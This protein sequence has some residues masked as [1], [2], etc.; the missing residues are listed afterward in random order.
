MGISGIDSLT[1]GVADVAASRRFFED[2]GLSLLDGATD[3]A[4]VLQLADGGTICLRAAN[5][6]ALPALPPGYGQAPPSTMREVIWGVH[7][8]DDLQAIEAELGRDRPV[9]RDAD[10]TLHTRDDL[11]YAI[12]FRVTRRHALTHEAVRD[13]GP[14][15]IGRIDARAEAALP[16]RVQQQRMVHL[17]Y[18]VPRQSQQMLQ[19][20]VERLGFHVTESVKNVGHFLRCGA[21]GDHHN[22]FLQTRGDNYGF[23]H[24]AFELRNIDDVMFC[25]QHMEQQGWKSHLGPGRHVL[26]SNVYWYFWCPAGGIVEAG[27]DLDFITDHWPAKELEVVPAGGSSWFVRAEDAGLRPGHGDWP[28]FKA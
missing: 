9:T 22:L 27:C 25:G 17:V 7:H 24:V 11:G 5:D 12:G 1:Y 16:Y 4:P 20:Y 23:Q 13:N 28:Q 8:A 10:G 26:G 14:G 18:W 15:R 19:F 6:T 3:S 2:W 21:S